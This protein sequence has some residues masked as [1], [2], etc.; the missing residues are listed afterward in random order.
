MI[1]FG[2]KDPGVI[3]RRDSYNVYKQPKNS[4]AI[5]VHVDETAP[6]PEF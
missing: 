2:F 4:F 1:K 5:G 6:I 3:F